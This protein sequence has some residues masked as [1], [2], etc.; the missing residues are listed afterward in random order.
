MIQANVEYDLAEQFVVDC[1][2]G[3]SCN[4]GYPKDAID[5]VTQGGI[6]L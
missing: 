3:S 5:M 1:T 2:S 4:G 6:P